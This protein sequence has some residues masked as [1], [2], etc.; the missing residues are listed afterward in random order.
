MIRPQ[1][2]LL[3][4][5]TGTSQGKSHLIANI[6]ACAAV[7]DILRTTLGPM[8]MDKLIKTADTVNI[9]NDGATILRLLDLVHPAAKTLVEI[10][11]SQDKEIGDGTTSVVLLASELLQNA[12]EFIE[13]GVTPQ[14][15][16]AG[17][18]AASAEALNHLEAISFKVTDIDLPDGG[19]DSKERFMLRQCAKTALNSKLIEN[20]KDFFA[21]M[22]VDAYLSSAE[23]GAPREFVHVKPIAGGSVRES[24]LVQ[25]VAF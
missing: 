18:R 7:A 20:E 14:A 5:G 16:I 3:K 6:N 4:E 17:Y 23:H 21:S 15:I 2:L 25:G 13:D 24:F 19:G 1:V 10:S 9:S 12:K 11:Q 8:G 22:L